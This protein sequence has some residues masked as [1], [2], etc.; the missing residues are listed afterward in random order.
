MSVNLGFGQSFSTI[1]LE[2]YWKMEKVLI[3]NFRIHHELTH[4]QY[5]LSAQVTLYI[6]LGLLKLDWVLLVHN[7]FLSG[8]GTG[9]VL[10]RI[11][12]G[13]IV[14]STVSSV[15]SISI[16]CLPKPS[17][18]CSGM[19][20]RYTFVFVLDVITDAFLAL[21]PSYLIM[22]VGLKRMKKLKVAGVFAVRLTLVALAIV[23]FVYWQDKLQSR[24]LETARANALAI[25]AVQLWFSIIFCMAIRLI[26]LIECFNTNSGMGLGFAGLSDRGGCELDTHTST[27]NWSSSTERDAQTPVKA[28][29]SELEWCTRE[30]D[31]TSQKS[32]VAL[33]KPRQCA[34]K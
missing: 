16:K 15:L 29:V 3:Y 14:L 2:Q 26:K 8:H 13:V 30:Q 22:P 1:T 6:S 9:P 17:E 18:A 23:S 19:S 21:L 34:Y 12:T 28:G 25:K 7:I 33:W 31:D 4:S 24:N 5:Y 27:R 20:T 10:I 11:T 32:T